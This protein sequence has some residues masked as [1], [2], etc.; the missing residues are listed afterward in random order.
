[1]APTSQVDPRVLIL[2]RIELLLLNGT[3]GTDYKPQLAALPLKSL[4]V[5]PCETPKTGPTADEA[6]EIICKLVRDRGFTHVL[7][8]HA[9]LCKDAVP[10]AAGKL[11]VQPITDV[12]AINV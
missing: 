5:V 4:H 1:M 2:S 12:I 10:R 6:S 7:S 11:D 3:K 8:S 9:G